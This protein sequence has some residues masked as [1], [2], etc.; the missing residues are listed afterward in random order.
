MWITN[1]FFTESNEYKRNTFCTL[2]APS[3]FCSF[4][5]ISFN[6]KEDKKLHFWTTTTESANLLTLQRANIISNTKISLIWNKRST[7]NQ[8]ILWTTVA[9]VNT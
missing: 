3:K 8:I 5:V 4:S 9:Y 2:S 6:E 7:F 1:T